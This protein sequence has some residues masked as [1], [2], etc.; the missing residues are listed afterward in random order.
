MSHGRVHNGILSVA[1]SV[2]RSEAT[3]SPFYF[4]CQKVAF[5]NFATCRSRGDLALRHM[6]LLAS[7]KSRSFPSSFFE[8]CM[9]WLLKKLFIPSRANLV[10]L[11]CHTR[12]NNVSYVR[13][14]MMH[15][16]TQPAYF[17]V[18]WMNEWCPNDACKR[19]FFQHTLNHWNGRL[20]FLRRKIEVR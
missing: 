9:G 6:V 7:H 15:S 1:W 19:Q 16:L 13:W 17:I 5:D 10:I 18:V 12:V 2:H 14:G 4:F 20:L 11:L 8:F 3:R